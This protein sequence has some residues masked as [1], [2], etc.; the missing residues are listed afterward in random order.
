[1]RRP[2]SCGSAPSQETEQVSHIFIPM[3]FIRLT[4][5]SCKLLPCLGIGP[6][7]RP[8]D[9]SPKLLQGRACKRDGTLPLLTE[10]EPIETLMYLHLS[11]V[12]GRLLANQMLWITIHTQWPS[13][14]GLPRWWR[15]AHG[16]MCITL[17]LPRRAV[18]LDEGS[19]DRRSDYLVGG[20]RNSVGLTEACD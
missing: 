5:G 4:G 3:G 11:A 12:V 2:R 6:V 17:R 10:A 18:L 19:G 7:S 14:I 13:R 9:L 8:C 1:M 20:D 16:L 15:C